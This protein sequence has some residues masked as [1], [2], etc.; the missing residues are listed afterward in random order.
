MASAYSHRPNGPVA[1]RSISIVRASPIP[2]KPMA[3]PRRDPRIHVLD[4]AIA[5]MPQKATTS[6]PA[7]PSAARVQIFTACQ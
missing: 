2:M 4:P 6:I 1:R 3:S 7:S 5:A